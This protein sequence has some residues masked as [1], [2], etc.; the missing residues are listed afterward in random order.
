SGMAV[1]IALAGMLIVPDPVFRSFAIGAILVVAVTVLVALTLLPAMLSLLGDRVNWLTL[2]F[3]GKRS[4]LK[5]GGGLWGITTRPVTARPVISVLLSGGLLIAAA[6][7]VF[8][9]HLGNVGISTAPGNRHPRHA[10]ERL[11]REWSA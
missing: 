5:G 7:P 9:M 1:A 11:K 8:N 10:F 2:P 4:E 3:I 6:V